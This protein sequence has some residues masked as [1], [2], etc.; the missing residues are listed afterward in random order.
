MINGIVSELRDLAQK[1]MKLAR[2]TGDSDISRALQ[3]LG[4]D[5]AAKALALE[6]K[7]D[8]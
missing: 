5:L 2:E 6:E 7:F 8:R 3:D 1:C 4:I